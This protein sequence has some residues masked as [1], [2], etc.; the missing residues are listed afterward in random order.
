MTPEAIFEIVG[1]IG[2]IIA[3]MEWR[4]RNLHSCLTRLETRIDKH[5]DK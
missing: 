2:V 5:L 3:F 1:P 4:Y